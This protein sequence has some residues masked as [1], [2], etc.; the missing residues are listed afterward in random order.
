MISTDDVKAFQIRAGR[1]LLGWSPADLANVAGVGTEV[2]R[3]AEASP[4]DVVNAKPRELLAILT[5]MNKHGVVLTRDLSRFGVALDTR[6]VN[7]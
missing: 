3:R 7:S 5:A 4:G 6:E 2:V 1:A